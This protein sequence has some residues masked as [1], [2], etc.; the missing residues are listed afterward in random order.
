MQLDVP[1]SD[2]TSWRDELRITFL[3]PKRR[4]SADSTLN[5]LSAGGEF[6]GW[7]QDTR[8]YEGRH[9]AAWLSVIADF[10]WSAKEI[11]PHLRSTLGAELSQVIA[12]AESLRSSIEG[13]WTAPGILEALTNPGRLTTED[14][15]CPG[16]HQAAGPAARWRL[17]R[18]PRHGDPGN[19]LEPPPRSPIHATPKA[20]PTPATTR[21]AAD[22]RILAAGR[23]GHL[24]QSSRL[25]SAESNG[26]CDLRR[27]SCCR[28]LT[29]PLCAGD[30]G[31]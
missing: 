16:R 2:P 21:F 19:G 23:D 4:W 25:R 22:A 27:R 17:G 10:M 20:R 8:P 15:L 12:T 18:C 30:G 6:D 13:N 26:Q 11:G 14:R 5:L 28:S 9:R 31:V 1:L 3:W 7:L 24:S 29:P